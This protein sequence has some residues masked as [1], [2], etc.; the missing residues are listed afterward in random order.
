MACR[1]ITLKLKGISHFKGRRRRKSKKIFLT[2]LWAF[3]LC[4]APYVRSMPRVSAVSSRHSPA[5]GFSLVEILVVV[6]VILVIAAISIPHLLQARMRA[7]EAAAVASMSIINTGETVYTNSY[8]QVGYAS[9]LADLGAHGTDCQSTSKTNS[10]IILDED[11]TGGFKSGYAFQLAGD[12]SVPEMR[13]TLTATPQSAGVSGRC[14]YTS[15]QN[16]E[17]QAAPAN[18]PV[19]TRVSSGG[20]SAC[21]QS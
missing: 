4:Y 9:K 3:D 7:N 2:F 20:G 21:G 8:P 15:D 10:C 6:M 19:A 18:L 11:L 17:I 5:R 12:G 16:A 14:T 1:Y 13:Y